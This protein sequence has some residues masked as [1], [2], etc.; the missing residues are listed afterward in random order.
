MISTACQDRSRLI[1]VGDYLFDPGVGLISGPSGAHYVSPNLSD[2]LCTFVES[3]GEVVDH[4]Y[5]GPKPAVND[6]KGALSRRVVRLR[7]YFRDS[8]RSPSYIETVPNQGYRLIAPV[9]GTTPKPVVT[10]KPERN[11][12]PSESGGLRSL[13]NEFRDR[14]VCRSMLIYSAIVWLVY[15]FTDLVVPALGLPEWVLTLVVLLGIT[16]FPIAAALSWIFDIT[17][18]GVVR[19]RHA[20]ECRTPAPSRKRDMVVDF[21]LVASAMAICALLIFSSQTTGAPEAQADGF[22]E[23]RVEKINPA[24]SEDA[25]DHFFWNVI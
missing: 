3:N 21:A 13:F 15:E 9:Y 14:K 4:D 5:H 20:S 19:D 17:P 12:K 1:I 25:N 2:L 22:E 6:S 7:Q 11:A 8:P 18:Q 23:P 10:Q 16:G 24:K